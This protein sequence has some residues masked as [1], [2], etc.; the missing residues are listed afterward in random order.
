MNK[1]T[2]FELTI[3]KHIAHLVMN[4]ADRMNS[5]DMTFWRELDEVLQ[6]LHSSNQ[7]R[8][9]VISSTGKHF[10][11]GMSLEAFSNSVSMDDQS[12]E[13]RAAIFDML[14]GLQSTFTRLETLRVPVI[15]AIQGG[16]IG[17][18]VDMVTACCLRYATADAFFCIQEINIGMVA[19]VG[20]LQRLPKLMP[21]T[22]V[23]ELAYTGRRLSAAK[24]LQ[25]GL[26]NE[27]L[28]DAAAALAAA[29]QAAAE[30]ASK[31]PVAVWGTKQALNYARDHSVDDALKQMAWLQSGI[32][33]NAHVQQAISAFQQK[34]SAVF[35]DLA[36]LKSFKDLA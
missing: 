23:K 20:T 30:I 29:M 21:M 9:L 36:P 7:A 14:G 15:A 26:V 27:V 25:Y 12:A 2:C 17:G 22:V 28:P 35:P 3:D 11:A 34:K 13:G 24:A 10:S 4:R 31:P 8:V 18:A 16:C 33:S 1:L 19:D 5:L 32:W 6:Q